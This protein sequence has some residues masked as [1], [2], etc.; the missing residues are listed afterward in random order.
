[1]K[2]EKEAE[3]RKGSRR[4]KRKQKIEKEAEDRKGSGR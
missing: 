3:E 4:K 1:L 2:K